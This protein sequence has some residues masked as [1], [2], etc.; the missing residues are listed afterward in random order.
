MSVSVMVAPPPGS[1]NAGPIHGSTP[2]GGQ[3]DDRAC[4]SSGGC[5]V[6]EASGEELAV[7]AAVPRS[8]LA[9]LL[10]LTKPRIVTMILVTAIVAALIAAGTA[11]SLVALVH[12]VIGT[13]LVAGSAGA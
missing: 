3:L 2:Q 13:A 12:L 11:V 4:V 10:Q 6:T 5:S 8:L 1:S 7:A 9:D